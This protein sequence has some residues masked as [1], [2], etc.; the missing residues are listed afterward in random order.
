MQNN[1]FKYLILI[2]FLVSISLIILL[3]FN[4]GSSIQNLIGGNKKLLEELQVQSKLQKLETDIIFIESSIRGFVITKDT[5]HLKGVSEEIDLVQK[6]IDEID[7]V[8]NDKVSEPMIKQ[9]KFLTKEK[10]DY[11]HNIL[12]VFY[13]KGKT[14]AENIINTKRGKEIRDSITAVI[15]NISKSRSSELSAISSSV[16]TNGTRAKSWGIFLAVIACLSCIITFWY[17]VSQGQRQQKL[18]KT[19]DASEKKVREM[20]QI[21][22]QFMANMSHEIRTPMN[23]ILGFTT[24]LQRTRLD[25]TQEEYVG[26]INS[27]AENLLA[28]INDILDLSRIEAGM[29]QIEKIPFNLKE[30]LNSVT[31][32]L[33]LKAKNKNLYLKTVA[34]DHLPAVLKGDAIRLTQILMNIVGNGL[35]FTHEGGVTLEVNEVSRKGKKIFIRFMVS[36]AG[37]GIE[38]EKLKNIFER[39]QQAE[40]DTSRRYGGT[41]LG[42][43]IVKQLVELQNGEITVSSTPDKGSVFTIILPYETTTEA[44]KESDKIFNVVQENLPQDIK[45]LL[46]EDNKMNRQLM[47]HL[48]HQW[49][50]DFDIAVNGI[51]AVKLVRNHEYDLILMDIQMPEMDGYTATKKI[52]NELHSSIPII[53]M[54]AH[55]LAGEKEKCLSLGMNDYLSKP[56]DEKNLYKQ[57]TKYAIENKNR[58]QNFSVIDL[59]YLH[60]ISNGDKKFEQEMISSFVN[61]IPGELNNLKNAVEK[62]DYSAIGSLAHG[63]KSSISYMGLRLLVPLLQEIEDGAGNGNEF[64]KIHN[65]FVL[66]E[67]TC[68][69]AINEAQELIED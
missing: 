26:S 19:L 47:K 36:D 51:E 13:S 54:T 29:M 32:M 6:E 34:D 58:K 11:G 23:A 35:K 68:K 50:I 37:I 60:S 3:Q 18:I 52:R 12:S 25:N 69:L 45:L 38:S 28:I 66:V 16:N 33:S 63:M 7:L 31:T 57:I 67:A 27:S 8:V 41:G 14:A 9:L 59:S 48:L 61:E 20:A 21:K 15:H 30:I 40:T 56:I 62:K 55:A 42:L 17:F 65:D 44:I 43:S 49:K 64:V 22:E 24:L 46:V 53:A 5:A 1:R 4:S 10:I 2:I 39:F